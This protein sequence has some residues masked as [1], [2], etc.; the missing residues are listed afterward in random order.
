MYAPGDYQGWTPATAPTLGSLTNDGN[1]DG[2]INIPS[3][4]SYEFKFTTGPDWSNALGDDGAGKLSPTG[5]N[6]SFGG[7]GFYHIT[8]NT[9][10]NTWTKSATTWSLIGSFSASNWSNDVDMT[11]DANNKVWKATITTA[12]GDQF[13]FRANHDWGLN[14]GESGGKG[15]LAVNGDNLGDA[16]KNFAVPA[17]SHNISLYLNNSGYYTYLIQ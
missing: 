11:Y 16:S 9:N 1:F 4:N 7:P 12:T 10:N 15:R 3:G 6:L 14:L 13:K 2:Y 8:V 5:G 17:G